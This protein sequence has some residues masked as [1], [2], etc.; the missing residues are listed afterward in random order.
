MTPT[1]LELLSTCCDSVRAVSEVPGCDTAVSKVGL[2]MDHQAPLSVTEKA[3]GGL[4]IS[5]FVAVHSL[6]IP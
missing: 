1:S 3:L 6:Y 4:L 2:T 5:S